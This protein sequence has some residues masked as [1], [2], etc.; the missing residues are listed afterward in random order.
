MLLETI[1]S[2]GY[3]QYIDIGD[4]FELIHKGSPQFE[5]E[6]KDHFS[7]PEHW[8]SQV[9]GFLNYHAGA[10]VEPLYT[11]FDQ[12]LLTERGEIFKV[13]QKSSGE[14]EKKL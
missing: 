4:Q 9:L 6:L 12:T 7:D 8:R 11:G 2:K 10:G 1:F 13:L 3:T 14:G 5:A